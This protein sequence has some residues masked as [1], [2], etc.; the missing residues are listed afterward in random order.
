ML[1]PWRREQP[2]SNEAGPPW[3]GDDIRILLAGHADDSARDPI[4]ASLEELGIG[5]VSIA[6]DGQTALD[7][8][9]NLHPEVVQPNLMLPVTDDFDVLAQPGTRAAVCAR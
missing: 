3:P 1:I 6:G 4:V 9:A 2:A 5:E 8:I 7:M